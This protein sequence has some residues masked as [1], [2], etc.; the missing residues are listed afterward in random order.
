[1]ESIYLYNTFLTCQLSKYMEV[2]GN[3][4]NSSLCFAVV[5][6]CCV[7]AWKHQW[8]MSRTANMSLDDM[9]LEFMPVN[10]VLKSLY[11]VKS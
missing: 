1:M 4:E 2:H 3:I 7:L 5:S 11:S 10:N 8:W 9:L 6:R